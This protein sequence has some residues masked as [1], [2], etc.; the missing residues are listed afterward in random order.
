MKLKYDDIINKH[1][2][3]PCVVALHG[4]SLNDHKDKIESLQREK[5]VLRISVNEWFDYFDEKP[6]YWVVSNGEFTIEMSMTG[7]PLWRA[8]EHVDDAF[9]VFN[10]PLFFNCASDLTSREFIDERL[11]C[12]YLPYDARHFKSHSCRE[13]LS[14]FRKHYEENKDLNFRYYGNNSQMWQ[15]PDVGDFPPWFQKIHGRVGAGWDAKERCCHNKLDI[16]LQEKLQQIAG[17]QQHLGAGQTVGLNAISFA[18]L[19]GCNPIFVTGLDLDYTLGYATS[20]NG[21]HHEINIG[22]VGHWKTSF[23]AFLIEDMRILKE[24]A[25]LLG[26]KIIN[27]NKEAWYNTLN[28]GELDI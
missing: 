7:H 6:D 27:L 5:A 23:R 16:T 1:K 8:R 13:I 15:K 9:N 26:I 24:S 2:D 14:N 18:V 19:M 3:Q 28:K 4:P 25:E 17:H 12:D 10:V 11:E 22:N 20:V 21:V